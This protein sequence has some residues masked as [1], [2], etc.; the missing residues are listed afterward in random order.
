MEA[1]LKVKNNENKTP[2]YFAIHLQKHDICN[3][4][5]SKIDINNLHNAHIY[6]HKAIRM[7]DPILTKK[8]LDS[9]I[10][11]N[12]PDDQGIIVN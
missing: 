1:F 6:L 10:D 2:L 5:L 9:G 7:R 8:F 4:I 3:L 12:A 11:V